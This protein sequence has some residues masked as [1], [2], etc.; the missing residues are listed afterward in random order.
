MEINDDIYTST[1]IK[2]MY[3]NPVVEENADTFIDNT[4]AVSSQF[5]ECFEKYKFNET[6]YHMSKR[7]ILSLVKEILKEIDPTLELF[8]IFN[9]GLKEKNI[10]VY[11]K[12]ERPKMIRRYNWNSDSMGLECLQRDDYHVSC[13]YISGRVM[14][15]F[16]L[17]GNISDVMSILHELFHYFPRFFSFVGNTGES[18]EITKSL[19]TEFPSVYAEKY[20]ANFLVKK[21]FDEKIVYSYL[22]EFNFIRIVDSLLC[23]VD[24][25]LKNI[26]H[27]YGEITEC[28]VLNDDRITSIIKN[29]EEI[30][31]VVGKPK[32]NYN[33]LINNFIF[34]DATKRK[35]VWCSISSDINEME[36]ES[37]NAFLKY[38]IAL[39]YSDKLNCDQKTVNDVLEFSKK[40]HRPLKKIN[41][42]DIFLSVEKLVKK[43]QKRKV[44]V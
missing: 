30:N 6:P 18:N 21:G 22:N 26:I 43:N 29:I 41:E 14:A 31:R 5:I 24:L 8:N 27:R 33:K 36:I 2:L 44:K 1:Y 20:A 35:K 23:I 37:D 39:Y 32:E 16:P 11:K 25:D 15:N 17:K 9:K 38:I 28:N 13:N 19:L 42:N 4:L 10:I 3:G 34:I 7:T 12:R 40:V